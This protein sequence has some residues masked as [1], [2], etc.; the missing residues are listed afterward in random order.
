MTCHGPHAKE[1]IVFLMNK[2]KISYLSNCLGYALT[3]NWSLV[4]G[5][6]CVLYTLYYIPTLLGK[7]TRAKFDIYNM[8]SGLY[9]HCSHRRA[10]EGHSLATNK[11]YLFC[12][13]PYVKLWTPSPKVLRNPDMVQPP[14][15]LSY[16]H[17]ASLASSM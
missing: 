9:A 11:H 16:G 4:E 1:P 2:K 14:L 6:L 13:S 15:T 8:E 10:P 17:G 12:S 7:D 3:C 5:P